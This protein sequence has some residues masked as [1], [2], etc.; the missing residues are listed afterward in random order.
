MKGKLMRC[1]REEQELVIVKL[2]RNQKSVDSNEYISMQ[3][4]I[5]L[6]HLK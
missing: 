5:V 2:C 6:L 4:V 1:T 3:N